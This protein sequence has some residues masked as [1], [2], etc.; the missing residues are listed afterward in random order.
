MVNVIDNTLNIINNR[1]GTV[2]VKLNTI[3]E[4]LKFVNL[5]LDLVKQNRSSIRAVENNVDVLLQ[6]VNKLVST[7]VSPI[8][9]EQFLEGLDTICKHS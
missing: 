3:G 1:F 8:P 2:N 5:G 7:K 9:D 6:Q 4:S